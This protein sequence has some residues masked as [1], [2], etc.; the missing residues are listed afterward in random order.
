MQL[1]D[2]QVL[3]DQVINETRFEYIRDRDNQNPLYNTPTITV[4]GA[5]T[6]GGNNEGTYATPR[7][8]MSC[9][10]TPPRRSEAHH[11]L[12]RPATRRTRCQ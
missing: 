11:P 2:T 1:S 5:F 10:T 7:I 6:G 9:R 8:T 4:Q 3:S 12:R